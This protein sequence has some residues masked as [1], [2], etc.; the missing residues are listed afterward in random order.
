MTIP[1]KD[2]HQ[3]AAAWSIEH[4]KKFSFEAVHSRIRK[5]HALRLTLGSPHAMILKIGC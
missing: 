5:E 1:G 2:L 3:Y 4:D